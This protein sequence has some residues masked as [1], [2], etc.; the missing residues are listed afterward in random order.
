MTI[1]AYKFLLK[2]LVILY[3]KLTM[4]EMF[5]FVMILLLAIVLGCNIMLKIFK[6][7]PFYSHPSTYPVIQ[8]PSFD[9]KYEHKRGSSGTL[10]LLLIFLCCAF[11]MMFDETPHLVSSD[12][13]IN[14]KEAAVS[15]TKIKNV[16]EQNVEPNIEPTFFNLKKDYI[17]KNIS[18]SIQLF[19]FENA[20]V[21]LVSY[22][23]IRTS[24]FLDTSLTVV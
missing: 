13:K 21:S 8:Q 15:Q 4:K 3:K 20:L 7:M 9:T 16:Y 19:Y 22:L 12:T 1:K 17:A 5:I 18:Y 10:F 14:I 2:L 11:F 23:L 6:A 24:D